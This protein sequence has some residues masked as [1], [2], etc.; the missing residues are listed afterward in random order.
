M[1]Y[2]REQ[3]V[4]KS[5]G[6]PLVVI[7]VGLGICFLIS[8]WDK[9]SRESYAKSMDFIFNVHWKDAAYGFYQSFLDTLVLPNLEFWAF[10]VT[11]GELAI[12]L[13][14]VFGLFTRAAA[15]AAIF[16][17]I[18]ILFASGGL[19]FFRS[20]DIGFIL[21]SWTLFVCSAGRVMGFDALLIQRSGKPTGWKR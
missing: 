8:S 14:F 15:V 17:G 9:I 11:W 18:N 5:P 21:G 12:G 4:K 1:S 10:V 19:T 20:A 2:F 7:R 13:A 6:A 16:L 3:L